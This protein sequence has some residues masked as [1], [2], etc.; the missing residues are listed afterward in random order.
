MTS[1]VDAP[2]PRIVALLKDAAKD[3]NKL[4]GTIDAVTAMLMEKQLAYKMRLSPPVHPKAL[5]LA[6]KS[7]F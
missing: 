5:Y 4:V 2:E 3:R 1:V 7:K 6:L